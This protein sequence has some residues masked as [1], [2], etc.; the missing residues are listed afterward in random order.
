MPTH[1][2]LHYL[3]W[4]MIAKR[5]I[6]LLKHQE[7]AVTKL[8]TGSVLLGG[9][10]S[11]K[12]MTSLAY[13]Q[14]KEF[15]KDLYVITT[16][17]KRDSLD[18]EREAANFAISNKRDCSSGNVLLVVDS[19]NNINKYKD[20]ADAFFIFDEQKVVGSGAWSK[21]FL[22]ITKKNNWILLTATPG[23]TWMDYVSIFVANGFY[24]NR[25]EFVRNHVVFNS[26]S[27]YP[28]IDRY[29]EEQKLKRLKDKVLVKMNF[30]RKTIRH[31]IDVVVPY[32]KAIFDRV[33][34]DRW[35]IFKNEPI[36]EASGACYVMR[37]VVNSH[38][39]RL[40]VI[41]E[42]TEKHKKIIVFYNFDYELDILRTLSD[43]EDYDVA[44]YNGHLH[45]D[46]PQSRNWVYLVQY[47][48]GAEAWNCVETNTI[49]FYSQNYSYKLM[50]QASGRIDR[51]NTEFRNLYYY[52]LRSEA[53]IDQGILS[54]LKV[55]TTFNE[56]KF[57]RDNKIE[58]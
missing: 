7:E 39:K 56:V 15:G 24:K 26:F 25:T 27:N 55:K 38:P 46:I 18:W 49:V 23:D 54:S 53:P 43:S 12:T 13:Y 29:I 20:I 28:K 9:V 47:I 21:A 34:K 30:E 44:E 52:H 10:G 1:Q 5:K 6:S 17:R 2:I 58:F 31:N 8:R 41:K 22:K 37:R 35:N 36:R 3:V 14:N 42:L 57:L 45:E 51:M 48:S 11:G 4:A 16:A 50:T 19:W 40:E 33:V 32:D